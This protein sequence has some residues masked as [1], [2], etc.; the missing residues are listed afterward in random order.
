MISKAVKDILN[1]DFKSKS[2]NSRTSSGWV[3]EKIKI[4]QTILIWDNISKINEIP[5]L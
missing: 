4:L 5:L 2:N 1:P 3:T